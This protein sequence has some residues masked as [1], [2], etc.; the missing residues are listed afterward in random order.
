[1]PQPSRG[2]I[3]T[4]DLDPIRGH[5]QGGKRPVL[6]L[7]ADLFNRG[8]A[9]LV[10]VLALS[11]QPK[12]VRSHVQVQPPEGGLRKTS[13]IRCEDIRSIAKERLGSLW[14]RV[15]PQTMAAVE[16]RVRI[17]LEL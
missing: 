4:A 10:I 6:I 17:L 9:D 7:S 2:E 11:S 15:S 13:Y 1:M 12:G 8:T 3:W 5:E 16:D 14:G